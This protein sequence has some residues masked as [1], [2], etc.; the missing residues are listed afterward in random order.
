MNTKPRP[1]FPRSTIRFRSLGFTLIELLTVIAI[2]SI[3]AAIIIP[4]VGK[5]RQAAQLS[6]ATS[7]IRQLQLANVLHASENKGRYVAPKLTGSYWWYQQADYYKFLGFNGTN[8]ADAFAAIATYRGTVNDLLKT[9]PDFGYNRTGLLDAQ[10][11]VGYSESEIP[12]PS[13]RI[14]FMDSLFTLVRVNDKN[15]YNGTELRHSSSSFEPAYRH[16]GKAL[17]A[18]WTASVRLIPRAEAIASA[19]EDMWYPNR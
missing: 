2:I 12:N 6:R 1:S 5:V 10:L 8:P 9:Y 17:V 3:L 13:R 19:N 7:N 15:L 18:F 4:T 16:N 11:P 14:A